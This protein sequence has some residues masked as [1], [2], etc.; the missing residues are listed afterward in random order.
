MTGNELRRARVTLGW[1]Q[2]ELARY[3][4]VDQASVSR[5]EAD[6]ARIPRLVERELLRLVGHGVIASHPISGHVVPPFRL[7]RNPP[8]T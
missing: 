1:T 5:W 8:I 6:R 7:S 2:R 4:G 3:C